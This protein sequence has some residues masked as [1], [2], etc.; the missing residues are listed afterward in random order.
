MVN[1]VVIGLI[2]M[3]P[4]MCFITGYFTLK[5]FNLGIRHNWELKNNVEPK[6]E[7]GMANPFESLNNKKQQ[8]DTNI[9][10]DEWL[11]GEKQ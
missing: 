10:L 5:A 1:G 7:P 2:I 4:I 3:M 6:R 9:I 11:N 8:A